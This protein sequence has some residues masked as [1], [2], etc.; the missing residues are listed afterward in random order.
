MWTAFQSGVL[1]RQLEIPRKN[2]NGEELE[3]DCP[4]LPHPDVTPFATS[5]WDLDAPYRAGLGTGASSRLLP[6]SRPSLT[7]DQKRCHAGDGF[8]VGNF[9]VINPRRSRS[10]AEPRVQPGQLLASS[11][12]ENLHRAIV[13]VAHPSR[14]LQDMRLALDKPAKANPL[15]PSANEK[16]PGEDGRSARCRGRH[17]SIQQVRGQIAEVRTLRCRGLAFAL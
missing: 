9:H 1:R 2:K 12:R 11:L 8:S 14:N 5:G 7:L 17:H 13:M 3:T 15:N 6:N 4:R 16:T 10:L